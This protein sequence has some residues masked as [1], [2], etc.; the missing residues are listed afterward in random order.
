[1]SA[2]QIRSL[3]TRRTLGVRRV[4]FFLLFTP[5][6]TAS[7]WEPIVTIALIGDVMLGRDV[8]Q[9]RQAGGWEAALSSL[10]PILEHA[11]FALANLESPI[12]CAEP[13]TE[14]PRILTAPIESVAALEAAGLN[15]ISLTNNHAL[16]AGREGVLCTENA[17]RAQGISTLTTEQNRLD[18]NL[19]GLEIVFLSWDM[20]GAGADPALLIQQVESLHALGKTI[21]V[22][23]HWGIAFQVEADPLQKRIAHRLTQAGAAVIWGHHP[24][25]VQGVERRESSVI[26]YSLGNAVFDQ[27]SPPAARRGMLA[28]IEL[29][30][31]GVRFVSTV[32]FDIH[33]QTGRAGWPDPGSLRWNPNP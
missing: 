21:I 20:V 32:L 33:P 5:L 14:D 1:M 15:I 18:V 10:A 13:F 29:D 8:A 17:L 25:V 31:R 9:A 30:A 26:L 7:A 4:V 24:H 16:D 27:Y 23:I 19:H 2:A 12:R 22:S 3:I 6:F 11:D 28:W